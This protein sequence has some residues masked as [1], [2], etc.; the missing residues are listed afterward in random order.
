[1]VVSKDVPGFFYI[2]F[3]AYMYL[4]KMIQFDLHYF[5]YVRHFN[6]S[7]Y[8]FILAIL[9]NVWVQLPYRHCGN[10]WENDQMVFKFA[11][12]WVPMPAGYWIRRVSEIHFTDTTWQQ[13]TRKEL[14]NQTPVTLALVIWG[15]AAESRGRCRFFTSFGKICGSILMT[16]MK[17]LCPTWRIIPLPNG[18]FMAY[19]WGW[20]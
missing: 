14:T 16:L 5:C 11:P 10:F 20:S 9:G 19:K 12:L 6:P 1:M 13:V 7:I 15:F 4:G 17:F 2:K 8:F 18:L 3:L